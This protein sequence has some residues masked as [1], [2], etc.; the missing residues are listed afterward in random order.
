MAGKWKPWVELDDEAT[1]EARRKR[2][3][4]RNMRVYKI[5]PAGREALAQYMARQEFEKEMLAF[6][7]RVITKYRRLAGARPPKK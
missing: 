1:A 6:A 3:E 2:R 5:S 4:N 7:A